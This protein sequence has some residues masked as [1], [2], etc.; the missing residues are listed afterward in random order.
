MQGSETTHLKAFACLLVVRLLP[1]PALPRLLPC[2]AFPFRIHAS[3]HAEAAEYMAPVCLKG[4]GH[5]GSP[6]KVLDGSWHDGL[7]L[8][9]GIAEAPFAS[10]TRGRQ[11][12]TGAIRA[13]RVLFLA[14]QI[15]VCA[16]PTFTYKPFP[17]PTVPSA[18]ASMASIS[19]VRKRRTLPE[20][21]S[22]SPRISW[23]IH[24]GAGA[25]DGTLWGDGGGT[26]IFK[27]WLR[28]FV[29]NPS[30]VENRE[31]TKCKR[32]VNLGAFPT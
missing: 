30:S 18:S 26:T 17:C 19:S 1:L 25:C 6:E 12:K 13:C 31:K 2:A 5:S 28:I 20:P 27:A 7:W 10:T 29:W 11:E 4:G 15:H 23:R 9:V 16:T 14:I 32:L 22:T 3:T 24:G 21:R 8:A